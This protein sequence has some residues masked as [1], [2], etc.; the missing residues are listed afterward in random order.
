VKPP[1]VSVWQLQHESLLLLPTRV[2]LSGSVLLEEV[3][4]SSPSLSSVSVSAVLG[5]RAGTAGTVFFVLSRL[6][7]SALRASSAATLA[8]KRL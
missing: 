3:F 8:R 1:L 4:P 6:A 5:S 2:S 7:S